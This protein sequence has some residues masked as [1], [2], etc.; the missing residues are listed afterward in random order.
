MEFASLVKYSYI[1][2]YGTSPR[3][4]SAAITCGSHVNISYLPLLLH[5]PCVGGWVCGAELAATQISSRKETVVII[6]LT[7]RLTI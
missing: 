3:D 4:Y 5:L 1:P 6:S 7:T 2:R